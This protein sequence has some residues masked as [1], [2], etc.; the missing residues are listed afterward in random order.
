[1]TSIQNI[2]KNSQKSNK[3]SEICKRRNDS[4]RY[5]NEENI[6]MENK[7]K[8]RSLLLII[9]REIWIKIQIR[10]YYTLKRKDTMNKNKLTA[11]MLPVCN[12]KWS[13]H[14]RRQCGIFLECQICTC[15]MI[16]TFHT[17]VFTQENRKHVFIQILVH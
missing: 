6:Q 12:I 4:N 7:H 10:Y 8:K 2:F 17:R 9:I 11:P 15:Q 1:M 16:N 5:I 3:K 13:N 14:L